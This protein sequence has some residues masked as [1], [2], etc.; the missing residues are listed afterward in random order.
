[1]E[2]Y[3]NHTVAD[4]ADLSK[5][6]SSLLSER[7]LQAYSYRGI[8]SVA[9]WIG[10]SICLVRFYSTAIWAKESTSF[11]SQVSTVGPPGHLFDPVEIPTQCTRKNRRR[12][13]DMTLINNDLSPLEMRMNELWNVVDLFFIAESTVPFKPDA[14]SKPLY[15]TAHWKDF[16]RFH[17]KMVI[18]VIPPEIS[19]GTGAQVDL[20]RYRTLSAKKCGGR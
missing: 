11:E 17:S 6:T 19:H 13:I 16:Y 3:S 5:P 20:V 8:L 10:C 7:R 9:L 1:M 15:L 14:K 18:F 12:V 2:T 4:Y